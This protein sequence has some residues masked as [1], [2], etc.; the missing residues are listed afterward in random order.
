MPGIVGIIGDY[1]DE[2][3]IR[4][5]LESMEHESFYDTH[6]YADKKFP[7]LI[8]IVG[9]GSKIV[10]KDEKISLVDGEIFPD[11]NELLLTPEKLKGWFAACVYDKKNGCFYLLTDRFGFKP[12]YYA[13]INGKFIFASEIKAILKYPHFSKSLDKDGVTDFVFFSYPLGETTFIKGINRFPPLSIWR[14]DRD[15][16]KTKNTYFQF[17]SLLKKKRLSES[18]S[19]AEAPRVFKEVMDSLVREDKVTLTLTGGYDTRTILSCTDTS[20]VRGFTF[21]WDKYVDCYRARQMSKALGF[22]HRIQEL[23]KEFYSNAEE[24]MNKTV[25]I[26]DGLANIIFAEWA[27]AFGK[28]KDY[29]NPCFTGV[30]G[31]ELIDGLHPISEHRITFNLRR[32][33]RGEPLDIE[34][35]YFSD[36]FLDV[37]R[38]KERA[39]MHSSFYSK[40]SKNERATY[41]SILEIYRKYYAGNMSVINTQAKVRMPYMD[42][43]LVSFVLSTP[44]SVLHT[45]SF[46]N[47]PFERKEGQRFAANIIKHNKPKLLLIPSTRG[48]PPWANLYLWAIPVLLFGKVRR[49]LYNTKPLS[50]VYAPDY[51]KSVLGLTVKKIMGEE[52]TLSRPYYDRDKILEAV[53]SYPNWEYFSWVRMTRLVSFELW[54]RQF[55]D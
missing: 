20:R 25:N 21:G 4:P 2:S 16:K 1:E 48:Y 52:R 30:G 39:E 51:F 50:N 40:L 5:M 41:F 23:D 53:R 11:K 35:H 47:N 32:L 12:L 37:K 3:V 15:M 13:E 42:P 49:Q 55:I 6:I 31:N 17:D 38:M 10:S 29:L 45:P 7:L 18:Q 26:S 19:L 24:F 46:E 43:D 34:L 33:I 22:E 14:F 44:F 36:K 27:Y 28:Q 9:E 8:G 54:V